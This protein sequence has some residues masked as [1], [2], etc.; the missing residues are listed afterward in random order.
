MQ[1]KKKKGWPMAM[2]V[3]DIVGL[4]GPELGLVVCRRAVSDSI[5]VVAM[6]DLK[7]KAII[8]SCGTLS[9]GRSIRRF[10]DRAFTTM[11]SPSVFD[12]YERQQK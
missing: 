5:F 6:R 1:V 2:P 10:R 12:E 7:P 11:T 8:A 4:L 9:S 3:Q